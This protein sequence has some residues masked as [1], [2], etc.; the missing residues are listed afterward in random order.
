MQGLLLLCKKKKK[1]GEKIKL[2]M[3]AL[4]NMWIKKL[5]GVGRTLMKEEIFVYL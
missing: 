3:L 4:V 5:E 2:D 1:W